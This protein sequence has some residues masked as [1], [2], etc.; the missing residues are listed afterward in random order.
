MLAIPAS[1]RISLHLGSY[2]RLLRRP[3]SYAALLLVVSLS[4][5]A[6]P[7]SIE[8]QQE[9]PQ[10]PVNDCDRLAAAPTDPD[11]VSAGVLMGAVDA[12]AAIAA[13]EQAVR[14]H[15]EAGRFQFQLGRSFHA[16][17]SYDQA[18]AWYREALENGYGLAQVS[19]GV[20][21]AYGQGVDE[22]GGEA[23]HRLRA[24][25]AGG[26]APAPYF[27]GVMYAY[28]QGVEQDDRE[29]A[30]WFLE[31]AEAGHV[32]A[33]S[34]LGFAYRDGVGVER[35]Y[36]EAVRWFRLAAES[37]H[38]D[39]QAS[40]GN[41][42]ETGRGAPEDIQQAAIWYQRAAEQG[43][44]FAQRRLGTFYLWGAGVEEDPSESL[45]WYR[46]A[47]EQ[48]DAQAQHRLAL[49]YLA[50]PEV[51]GVARDVPQGMD[52]L[53]QSAEGGSIDAQLLLAEIYEE[54]EGGEASPKEA[55]RWYRAAAEQGNADAQRRM[56]Q[57]YTAGREVQHD[58][59]EAMDWARKA[60]RQGDLPSQ[61][62]LGRHLIKQ[63]RIEEGLEW[64][65]HA[66]EGGSLAA[67]EE[68]TEIYMDGRVVTRSFERARSY[69]ERILQQDPDHRDARFFLDVIQYEERKRTNPSLQRA[70]NE[71]NTHSGSRPPVELL[72]EDIRLNYPPG[73][74]EAGIEGRVL[75]LL[76]VDVAGGVEDV[77]V[78]RSLHPALDSASV[79]IAR[80]LRFSEPQFL[81]FPSCYRATM[82]FHWELGDKGGGR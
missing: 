72:T 31:A 55:V 47:A 36:G 9:G 44:I 34:R 24:A 2:G 23:E 71:D 15:P 69:A 19:I 18:L 45:R 21:Y 6:T 80:S 51:G 61:V 26:Y 73:I 7:G 17:E 3:P 48:G 78:I 38:A 16:E 46:A 64:F 52:W 14:R 49:L 59:E 75:L 20:M 13:C 8:A 43:N 33:Q 32:A 50:G 1:V 35:D 54:G 22:D 67:A 39:A 4:F 41:L 56:A 27:L 10:P 57:Y 28:G 37:G 65:E 5:T 81:G 68:L 82:P 70:C 42:Y 60:A 66:S 25:A 74:R 53:R 79:E 76:R 11:K 40:L 30:R 58:M 62:L 63:G 77:E 12:S 29:A